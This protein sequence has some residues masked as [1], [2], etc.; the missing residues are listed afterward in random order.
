MTSRDAILAKIRAAQPAA[1]AASRRAALQRAGRRSPRALHRRARADGRHVRRGARLDD[2]R[3]LI[4][5]RFG[6]GCGGRVG[7]GRD[8][9]QPRRSRP[10][11]RR[12]RCRTSMSA[13]CAGD[14]ASPKRARCG[15]AK[16]STSSI[17]SAISCSISS[18]CSIR[19]NR[20]W[21]AGGLSASGF[22]VGALC[23][24]RDRAVGDRRYRRRADSR[25]AGR[26]VADRGLVGIAAV[27]PRQAQ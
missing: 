21:L 16:P 8:R 22:S 10:T 26:E 15:S 19:R 1:A 9:R 2:V 11:R 17:R 25:R 14:S 18:C 3:A 7:G 5:A 23:G 20:R 4:V 27:S 6:A 24:A 13:W 12:R